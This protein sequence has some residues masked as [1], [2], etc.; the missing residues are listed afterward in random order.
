MNR[1]VEA[2]AEEF[3]GRGHHVRVLAPHVPRPPQPRHP[4]LPRRVSQVPKYPIPLGRSIG[5]ASN[6][7]SPT[8]PLPGGG[9]IAPRRE[10]RRGGFD[11]VHV[12]EPLVPLVGWNATLGARAPAVGTFHAYST[13]ALPQPH[14]D[15][16]RRAAGLQPALG[17][18]R[19]LRGSRLERAALVW[20]PIRDHP[21][22]RR[23]RRRRRGA[24][25]AGKELRV[26]FVGRAE[27][28]KGLPILL[29][30]FGAL[31]DMCPAGSPSWGPSAR[32]SF[33][34][35]PTPS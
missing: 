8:S 23:R 31:V 19:R 30:A 7:R 6:Q 4:P 33:T 17:P 3:L 1:H 12:H 34:T 20:R 15:G 5:F 35:S 26:L 13:K 10:L 18:D 29:A 25:P 21:Q 2:L 22:R 32:R 9:M 16:A 11:V 24:E 28:R 14:W 27:E